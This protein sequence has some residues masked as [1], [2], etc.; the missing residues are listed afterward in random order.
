MSNDLKQP[1]CVGGPCCGQPSGLPS[2]TWELRL[3]DNLRKQVHHYERQTPSDPR[4]Y[5]KGSKPLYRLGDRQ[6]GK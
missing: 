3:P 5:F 2:S 4:F 1:T 6:D